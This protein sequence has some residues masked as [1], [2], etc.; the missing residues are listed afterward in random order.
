MQSHS[1]SSKSEKLS[2]SEFNFPIVAELILSRPLTS[3][4]PELNL[5][6]NPKDCASLT[7]SPSEF[8]L[9]SNINA[10]ILFLLNSIAAL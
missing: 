7:K 5:I 1:I 6:S 4:T 9:V 3:A 10:L 2:L 8:S